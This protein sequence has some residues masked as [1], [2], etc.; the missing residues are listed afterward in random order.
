[1]L[2]KTKAKFLYYKAARKN[3]DDVFEMD[4]RD[5]KD[6]EYA[7]EPIDKPTVK[8]GRPKKVEHENR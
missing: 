1:M 2:V 8:R 5:V 3:K 6:Y 4:D 7:V